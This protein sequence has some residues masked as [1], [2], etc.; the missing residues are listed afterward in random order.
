M[1]RPTKKVPAKKAAV[2]KSRP[3]R[4]PAR[5]AS[6]SGVLD[7]AIDVV[8]WVD[9][10]FKL[11]AVIMLGVFG[12]AGWLV[13]ENRD[14][15]VNKIVT[16]DAMPVMVND[17]R[18]IQ[19]GQ[20]ALKDMNAQTMVVYSVDLAKNTRTIKVAL[21]QKGRNTALENKSASF[22]SSSPYRNQ[23]A[24]ALLTGEMFC[25]PFKPSSDI[26]DWLVEIGVTYAC[27][28]AIPPEV[29]S[30]IGY[31]TFGF[32]TQPRDMISVKTRINQATAS[33]AR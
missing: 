9:S 29:G 11:I 30:M 8:K 7:K 3:A 25:E 12:L 6:S 14:K 13:Y 27:R 4:K 32:A 26:G 20:Q 31:A 23:A 2:K 16:Y 28:A 24:I 15:L 10:P 1:R 19:T 33:M 21:S 5:G 22:F 17:E 18:L